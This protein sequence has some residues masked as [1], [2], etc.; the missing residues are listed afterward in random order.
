MRCARA[1]VSSGC[2]IADGEYC[3]ECNSKK[4]WE[5]VIFKF[6]DETGSKE[7]NECFK[8]GDL[9]LQ[10]SDGVDLYKQ[11]FSGVK[12]LSNILFEYIPE[13]CPT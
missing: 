9:E 11:T 4:G 2:L 10:S 13:N 6:Y 12:L 3:L 7:I 5:N 1:S 8:S